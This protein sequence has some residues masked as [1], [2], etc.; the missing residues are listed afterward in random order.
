[1]P[2][3]DLSSLGVQGI[4]TGHLSRCPCC[5]RAHAL[6]LHINV[7]VCFGLCHFARCSSADVQ[8]RP[9]NAQLFL[10]SPAAQALVRQA[11]GST[12][13][14][15]QAEAE[16]ACSDF[17]A[18]K[19]MARTSEKV[20]EPPLCPQPTTSM[21]KLMACHATASANRCSGYF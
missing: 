8:L 21:L 13:G 1:M 12:A 4:P 11:S 14:A 9:P 17:N 3:M 16:H 10:A 5:A 18:A 19:A 7:D 20:G 15:G 6:G 2:L